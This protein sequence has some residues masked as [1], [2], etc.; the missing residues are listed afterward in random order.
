MQISNYSSLP[1]FEKT[2]ILCENYLY[3]GQRYS[4]NWKENLAL[5]IVRIASWA[6]FAIPAIGIYFISNLL[7]H[8]NPRTKSWENVLIS[9][10][11]NCLEDLQKPFSK[12]IF[13]SNIGRIFIMHTHSNGGLG[14]VFDTADGQFGSEFERDFKKNTKMESYILKNN[15]KA[16]LIIVCPDSHIDSYNNVN[17]PEN[18]IK[19]FINGDN[20]IYTLSSSQWNFW[21]KRLGLLPPS[22][23]RTLAL[24]R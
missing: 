19:G 21:I 5:T 24:L 16:L 20:R 17:W 3:L 2:A 23:R 12:L 7:Q 4:K 1:R 11:N 6:I 22:L 13:N 10:Y 15:K 8:F 18:R 9:H 14:V